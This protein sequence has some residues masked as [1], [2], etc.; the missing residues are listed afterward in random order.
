MFGLVICP[1]LKFLV[2]V[3]SKFLSPASNL[4]E[5]INK[6]RKKEKEKCRNR[7]NLFLGAK[8]ACP[9]ASNSKL[10]SLRAISFRAGA[11]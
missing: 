5:Y 6:E 4:L 1:N 9:D 11:V 7:H 2:S 3:V 10:Y 8:T